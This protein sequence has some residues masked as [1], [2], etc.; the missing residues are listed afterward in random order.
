MKTITRLGL[1]TCLLLFGFLLIGPPQE[2]SSAARPKAPPLPPV[3]Y[4]IQYWTIPGATSNSVSINGLNNPGQIVGW[5]IDLGGHRRGY[6]YDPEIDPVSAVDLE[7]M[8]AGA[9]VPDGW[10]I[11]GA[12]DINDHGIVVGSISPLGDEGANV[13]EGF[14]LDI[15]APTPQIV[16]LPNFGDW[17]YTYAR[18]INENGDVLGVYETASGTPGLYFY[19]PNDADSPYL[20]PN[21]QTTALLNNP[22][23]TRPAQVGGTFPSGAPFRWTPQSNQ[24]TTFGSFVAYGGIRGINDAGT[25]CGSLRKSLTTYPMRLNSLPAQQLSSS[26]GP[27]G[28]AI[29]S[30]GDLLIATA[31][32]NG[33]AVYRDDWGAY[34]KYGEL[35]K[36]VVGTS[37]EVATWQTASSVA[38]YL[39]ND[40]D[41]PSNAGQITGFLRLSNGSFLPF[42]LTPVAP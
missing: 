19:N 9:G 14:V 23:G 38:L 13:R 16:V 1:V 7:S 22:V 8:I 28:Q 35:K 34:G 37:S 40:R 5:Y 10:T 31:G 3:R 24:L 20:L 42:L 6:L 30:T 32:T 33:G 25:L 18:Q 11:I 2:E 21:V 15:H 41:L 26:Y 39:M 12:L 17:D 4:D 27:W 36:L 29:N